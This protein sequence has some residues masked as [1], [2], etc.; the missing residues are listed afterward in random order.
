[1]LNKLKKQLQF[2]YHKIIPV[3]VRYTLLYW[4]SLKVRQNRKLVLNYLQNKINQ[5]PNDNDM[6]IKGILEFV[7]HNKDIMIPY[8]FVKEYSYKN[9]VIYTDN[10]W[11]Y[12][13]YDNKRIYF[14]K[15]WPKID[16]QLCYNN[17]L[18]EQDR[19]S[20]HCYEE[21]SFRVQTSDIVADVGA[22]EGFF[23][24]SVIEKVEKVYLFEC[25]KEWIE[26]LKKTFNPWQEKIEIVNKYV[27]DSNNDTCLTLDDFF[28]DKEVNFIKADIEGAEIALLNGAKNILAKQKNLKLALCTYHREIDAENIQ[29]VLKKNNFYTEFSSGYMLCHMNDGKP[30][31]KGIIRAAK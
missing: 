5:K 8:S 7:K 11:K 17:I 28:K 9:V 4:R 31:R 19:R 6:E 15:T 12:V 3:N 14:P 29:E 13:L 16:I 1:M 27:S 21:G 2:L 26:A 25:E 24:L 30:L 22:A 18:C 23:A 20:P 10:G